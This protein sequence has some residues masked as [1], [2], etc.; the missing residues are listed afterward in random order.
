MLESERFSDFV[1]E[2][3][4][5]YDEEFTWNYYLHRV[6]DKNYSDYKKEVYEKTSNHSY[7][8]KEEVSQAELE[9]TIN[10]SKDIAN[11][12]KKSPQ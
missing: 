3:G 4:A 11:R 2:L 10:Q 1:S 5:I 9:A 6:F 12:L 7:S 8:P